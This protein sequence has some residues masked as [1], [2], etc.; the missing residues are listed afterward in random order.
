MDPDL[1]DDY[2]TI[3]ARRQSIRSKI[4]GV[5][6]FPSSSKLPRYLGIDPME[7][8]DETLRDKLNGYV[9]N[10]GFEALNDPRILS[11][12]DI[13]RNAPS[14]NQVLELENMEYIL[15]SI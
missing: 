6:V 5:S 4:R 7:I 3:I 13:D 15:N 10:M 8:E 9:Q 2:N 12:L 14:K 1:S 11:M